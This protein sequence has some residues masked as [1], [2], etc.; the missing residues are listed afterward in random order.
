M[1]IRDRCLY[2][3]TSKY[4]GDVDNIFSSLYFERIRIP[5]FVHGTP[6]RAKE[7]LQEEID[8]DYKQLQHVEEVLSLIHI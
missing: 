5:E 4:E 1:C 6:E 8:N 3:T 2:I 7:S